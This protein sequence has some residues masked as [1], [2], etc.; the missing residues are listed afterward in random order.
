MY[1]CD[2]IPV[3]F[4]KVHPIIIYRTVDRVALIV[5]HD[6]EFKSHR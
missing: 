3:S 6:T 2:K 5:I 1:K 4:M